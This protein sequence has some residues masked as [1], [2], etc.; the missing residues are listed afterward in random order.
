MIELAPSILSADFNILGQQIKE[1]ETAGVKWLHIDVMDG[2]FVPNISFGMPVIASIRKNSGMFFDVH[3]MVTEPIRYIEDVANAGADMIT[4]HLEACEDC[5]ATLEKI[6]NCGCKAGISIKPNTSV[7]EL[8]PFLDMVDMVLVM[9]VHPGM[10]GQ[11]YIE[12]STE[13]IRQVKD[14][15]EERDLDIDLQVDGGINEATEELVIEAGANILVEGSAIFRGNLIENVKN[16][17]NRVN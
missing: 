9:T 16:F 7:G 12:A 5:D 3:M 17:Q 10:G 4:V 15:I 14:M 1:L 13:R 6:R 2:D 8:E 11:S